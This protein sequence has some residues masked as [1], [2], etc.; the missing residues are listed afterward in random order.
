MKGYAYC[1]NHHPGFADERRLHASKAS[2]EIIGMLC[3][4]LAPLLALLA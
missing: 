2:K 4:A 1:H 3:L